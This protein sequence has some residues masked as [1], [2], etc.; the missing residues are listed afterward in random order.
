M[1]N[2]KHI[3]ELEKEEGSD[4]YYLAKMKSGYFK[5]FSWG[6]Y[7]ASPDYRKPYVEVQGWTT[8]YCRN[9]ESVE[10]CLKD[11]EGWVRLK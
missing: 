4:G 5:F 9:D 3:L 11:V 6:C 1:I 8:Y 10:L 2:W 7:D